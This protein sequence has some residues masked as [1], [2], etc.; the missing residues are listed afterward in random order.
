MTDDDDI[1]SAEIALGLLDS[2]GQ[3][4]VD[5]R[6]A[7]DAA[8]ATRVAW[9]RDQ[10]APLADELA[11]EPPAALWP[12]IEARLGANDNDANPAVTRWKWATAA[13]SALAAALLAV[14]ALRPT[15][16]PIVPTPVMPS[17]PMVTVMSGQGGAAGLVYDRV[18]GT[19]AMTPTSLKAGSGDAELWIIPEGGT[20]HS[21]GIVDARRPAL[22][23]VP[24]PMR[25][26]VK[27]GATFAI[28]HE[29]KGGSTT[30]APQGPV[31]ATGKIIN[32]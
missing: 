22:H 8:L 2:D 9:W 29:A 19:L 23:R 21:L 26:M 13:T 16:V 5:A 20:P 4:A 6:M 30:G 27:A 1:L 7:G 28:S 31:V 10:L 3:G 17:A 32:V 25:A 14:I 11:S 24:M 12:R 18:A 15:P